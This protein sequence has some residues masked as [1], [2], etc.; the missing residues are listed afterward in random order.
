MHVA[1]CLQRPLG[2]PHAELTFVTDYA[3]QA[4]MIPIVVVVALALSWQRRWRVLAAWIG[5]AGAVLGT[6]L[7][8]KVA[9]ATCAWMVTSLGPHHADL[10]SPSGHTASAA[11][12]FAGVAALQARRSRSSTFWTSLLTAAAV[13][14]VIGVTRV[15]LGAHSLSEVGLAAVIGIA[16]A[17]AFV[18][19]AGPPM[20]AMSGRPV[21]LCAALAAVVMHGLHLPAEAAIQGR[22]VA[23]MQS[24]IPA[25][26]PAP[27][28]ERAALRSGPAAAR[29]TTPLERAS[30]RADQA[31][32]TL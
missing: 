25:C 15:E 22:G 17:I 19:L 21:L 27:V 1:R 32:T 8:L 28:S 5:A 6:I 13:A 29:A 31:D 30:S 7:V 24:V 9:C 4:V 11:M 20:R 18:A 10:H 3:D 23:W 26:D 16:G 2:L 12:I 14:G